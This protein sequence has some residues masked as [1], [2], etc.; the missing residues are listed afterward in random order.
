MRLRGMRFTDGG[1]VRVVVCVRACGPVF[2]SVA[3]R[4]SGCS[5][6]LVAVRLVCL[7][8][9]WFVCCS[10]GLVAPSRRYFVSRF[11]V[12]HTVVC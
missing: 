7:L 4:F 11:P 10:L 6:G 9:A 12:S 1:M 3:V 2:A 5:L 8:F